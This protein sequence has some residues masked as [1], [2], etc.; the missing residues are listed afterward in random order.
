MGVTIIRNGCDTPPPWAGTCSHCGE[1]TDEY[2]W[3]VAKRDERNLQQCCLRGIYPAVILAPQ[4]TCKKCSWL[5]Q[6][7]PNE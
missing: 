3:E 7:L 6:E 1:W 2:V 5:G 4:F